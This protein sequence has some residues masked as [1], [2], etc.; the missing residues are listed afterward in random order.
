M[1][2]MNAK[3]TDVTDYIQEDVLS[4][5]IKNER[6]EKEKCELLGFIQDKDKAIAD[7]KMGLKW[8]SDN[9]DELLKENAELKEQNANLKRMFK[10]VFGEKKTESEENA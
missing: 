2:E 4:L 6:L 5:R 10:E 3:T 9:R 7:L 8:D 1:Y